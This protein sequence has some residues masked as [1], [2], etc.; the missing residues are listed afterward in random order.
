MKTILVVRRS[1][2]GAADAAALAKEYLDDLGESLARELG[3]RGFRT[4][5]W[6]AVRR[7]IAEQ[8]DD[9][10]P[11]VDATL[12]QFVEDSDWQKQEDEKYALPMLLLRS[13]GRLLVG[14]RIIELAKQDLAY[15]V[16]MRADAYDLLN[17]TSFG[18]EEESGKAAIGDRTLVEARQALVT[19]TARKLVAKL[20]NSLVT[21]LEQDRRRERARRDY[22]FTFA[23]W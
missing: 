4:K 6:A 13:Q 14:F 17:D 22:A 23:G 1:P 21:R 2:A 12:R 10:A 15:H 3:G 20:A 19:E 16:T 11:G 9:A 5:P 18:Y 7:S 8:R